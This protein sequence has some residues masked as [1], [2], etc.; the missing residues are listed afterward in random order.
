VG[1]SAVIELFGPDNDNNGVSDEL[2]ALR[3]KGWLI[4]EAN[5]VFNIDTDA[6]K[7]DLEA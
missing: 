7:N 6:M 4:N 3:K 2:E 5:L 1:S